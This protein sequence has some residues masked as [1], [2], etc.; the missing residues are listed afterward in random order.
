[1]YVD[2]HIHM[3]KQV[4]SWLSCCI[5]MTNRTDPSCLLCLQNC[6]AI[7]RLENLSDL[8]LCKKYK[9]HMYVTRFSKRC[10]AQYGSTNFINIQ[11]LQQCTN[12]TC[13]YYCQQLSSFSVA[14]FSNV[15]DIHGY[16]NSL[17]LALLA[18]VKIKMSVTHHITV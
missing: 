5:K 13:V 2:I 7:E 11:Q 6:A 18:I 3:C 4:V 8:I 15:S 14:G 12:S 10:T 9:V 1:M 17:Q 16:S